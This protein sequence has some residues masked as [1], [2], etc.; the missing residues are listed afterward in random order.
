M[1]GA[2]IFL[3]IG[4]VVGLAVALV[5]KFFGVQG[6]PLLEQ[7]SE[8]M[9]G[10][11]CGGCGYA[12]CASYAKA[13]AERE[14]RPGACPSM[15][16]EAAHQIA[17]LTGMHEEEREPMTAVVLCS[18]DED[19]ASRRAGYNGVNNCRDAVLVAQGAKSCSYGCLG[20]GACAQVCQFGAIEITEHHIAVVH[21]ELC[22]ACGRC[23]AACPKHLIK[24]VPKSMPVQVFCSSP[25]RGA[26]KLK[27]CKGAC[28][29]CGKCVRSL[30]RE[31]ISLVGGMAVVNAENPP[32]A[33]ITSLCPTGAL[34][35]LD[36]NGG[37]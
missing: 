28:I 16:K 3:L 5:V 14:A 25:E 27:Y 20:L 18:G 21:P 29:G 8:L 33:E 23:V 12:G 13:L 7:I 15:S 36:R 2:L 1:L 37:K 31:H 26:V 6:N 34:R 32:S 17:V 24:L 22:R 11:N 19:K 30:G 10:A 35:T 9:P 4:I